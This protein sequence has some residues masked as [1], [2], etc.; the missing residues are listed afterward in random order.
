MCKICCTFAAPIQNFMSMKKQFS[1]KMLMMATVA[2]SA[3][4]LASCA[5]SGYK[6]AI[7]ADA[8]VVMELDVKNVALK[9][10]FMTQKNDIAD[11]V[12]SIEPDNRM[13]RKIAAALRS[14][15]DLGLDFLSPMYV[16]ASSS[17]DDGFFL[18]SVRN[19]DDLMAKVQ[20]FSNDIEFLKDGDISWVLADGRVVGALT[21]S[22]LLVGS[23]NQKAIYRELLELSG[24]ESFFSTDAGKFM[25][26]HSADATVMLNMEALTKQQQRQLR[27]EVESELDRDLRF[28]STDE[29]WEKV[30]ETR[31]ALNLDC[32]AGQIALNLF[33][34]NVDKDGRDVLKK[35]SK[36]A[37]K[38]IPARNLVGLVALGIN[39]QECWDRAE[40]Q[41]GAL[42]GM[43]GDVA[44]VIETLATSTNG[45]AV[46][47]L[48]GKDIADNPEVICI[49]PTP[50]TAIKPIITLMGN[51]M[52]RGIFVEGDQ[53]M[54]ALTNMPDYDFENVKSSF[55]KASNA[56]SCYLYGYVDAK[57]LVEIAMDELD[58]NTDRDMLKL[59]RKVRDFAS[60]ADYMELKAEDIDRLQL[61]LMLNDKS[62]NS[63][64]L[65]VANGIQIGKAYLEYEEARRASYRSYYDASSSATEQVVEEAVEA[66]EWDED[67]DF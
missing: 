41:M 59:N 7:P 31:L 22:T 14:P 18:A 67:W 20:T 40:E 63:L 2:V 62:K 50:K 65:V 66:Y 57:P 55:D 39:G 51:D 52:P 26:K 19:Q 43:L 46:V 56:T 24:S 38:Q 64:A 23:S 44:D 8:P 11:L 12:E 4:F 60:L 35:I 13:Y 9:A 47:S 17:I 36:D 27:R 61:A 29:L 42:T 37:L 49:L 53:K 54:T 45:T 15:E 48:S 32:N 30:F 33:A 25:K 10:D 5:K 58:D 21:K 1:L 3:L 34:D 28:L 16:F 6:N